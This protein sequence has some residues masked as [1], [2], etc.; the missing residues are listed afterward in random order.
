MSQRFTIPL[1]QGTFAKRS[2]PTLQPNFAKEPFSPSR[3]NPKIADAQETKNGASIEVKCLIMNKAQHTTRYIKH[4]A[5]SANFKGSTFIKHRNGLIGNRFEMPNVSYVC[6]EAEH[7]Q[8]NSSACCN[9]DG[10]TDPPKSSY[11]GEP[12]PRR[13]R[14]HEYNK[15]DIKVNS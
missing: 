15:K 4:L 10:G 6:R 11:R 7:R 8:K 5:E 12:Q 1:L 9:R 2:K 3:S 13:S 14:A